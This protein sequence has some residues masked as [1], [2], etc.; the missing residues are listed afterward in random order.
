MNSRLLTTNQN[1]QILY[2]I[3]CEK[4]VYPKRGEPKVVA[5]IIHMHAKT[6]GEARWNF[7]QDPD[8]KKFRIVAVAPAIGFFAA[9]DNA[10]VL[11]T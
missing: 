3:A 1:G 4:T 7:C 2:A 8:Y 6:E 5:D 10:D 11:I 9:D